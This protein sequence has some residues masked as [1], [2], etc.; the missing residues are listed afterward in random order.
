M[1]A[2]L[3]NESS[4]ADIPLWTYLYVHQFISLSPSAGP[5]TSRHHQDIFKGWR[6]LADVF[7]YLADVCYLANN[8]LIF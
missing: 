8:P 5:S 4:R 1:L 7:H 2:E 6:Y 3:L